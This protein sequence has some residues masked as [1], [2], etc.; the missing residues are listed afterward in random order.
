MKEK[1]NIIIFYKK[2][3]ITEFIMSLEKLKRI[4]AIIGKNKNL[5]QCAGGNTS[6][7]NG[8]EMWIKA[9]GK[10]LINAEKENIFVLVDL[11][12]INK[13]IHNNEAITKEENLSQK[14]LKPSIETTLHALMPHAVVLHSH[15]VDLLSL[16]VRKDGEKKLTD[17]MKDINWT[18][19]S[20]VR[21]GIDLTKAV[22]THIRNKKV[23]VIILGNHGLV[24]GGVN[25]SIAHKLMTD[26][27]KRCKNIPRDFP[28][29]AKQN[30]KKLAKKFKMREPDY[31]I[32]HALALD[33][34]AFSYCNKK[35]GILYPDQAVF[36]GAKM[37]CISINSKLNNKQ[38]TTSY[39]FILEKKGV[40]VSAN[41]D[42]NIDEML[43]CHAEILLRIKPNVKLNYLQ[44]K[45][46]TKLL[47]WEPEKYRQRM[48]Q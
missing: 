28:K 4:S 31:K 38:Q 20:Y 2:Y 18:W 34:V 32:I 23:D 19:I 8:N 17:I 9:S 42:K 5:V 25:C 43:R 12:K 44:N 45:E 29:P 37:P 21:P 30:I 11:K 39:F 46:V 10:W 33:K 14:N 47:D 16:L 15:P 48:L 22:Q 6:F 27:I 40:L 35:N 41:A 1:E 3:S 7:K 13:K 36:L 26:I 24:V